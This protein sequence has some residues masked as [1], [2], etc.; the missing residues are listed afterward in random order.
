MC[1][2]RGKKPGHKLTKNWQHGGNRKLTFYSSTNENHSNNYCN[3]IYENKYSQTIH[4]L[5]YLNT[6]YSV[7]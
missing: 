2:I 3:Q 1:E 4:I 6:A 7:Y 5:E